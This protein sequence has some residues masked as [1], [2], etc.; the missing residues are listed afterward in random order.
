[1]AVSAAA[2]SSGVN[3]H[4]APRN[5]SERGK[6]VAKKRDFSQ[7]LLTFWAPLAAPTGKATNQQ[8]AF[9]GKKVFSPP[10]TQNFVF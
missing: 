3:R 5:P 1:M 4:Q 8:R 6:H 2:Y 7:L 9:I 10:K